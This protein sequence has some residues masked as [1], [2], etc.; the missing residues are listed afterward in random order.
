MLTLVVVYQIIF[1]LVYYLVLESK[2]RFLTASKKPIIEH[3]FEIILPEV[4]IVLHCL[5]K[6]VLPPILIDH[7]LNHAHD[8][9]VKPEAHW[10]HALLELNWY[11]RF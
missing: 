2:L 3:C 4:L 5:A 9:I 10:Q 6:E 7:L 1:F 11:E 8:W